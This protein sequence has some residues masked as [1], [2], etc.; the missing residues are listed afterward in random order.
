MFIHFQLFIPFS[1]TVPFSFEMAGSKQLFG[2]QQISNFKQTSARPRSWPCFRTCICT[3]STNPWNTLQKTQIRI[4]NHHSSY[5]QSH[6]CESIMTIPKCKVHQTLGASLCTLGAHLRPLNK[7]AKVC[8]WC[9]MVVT[10]WSWNYSWQFAQIQGTCN[11]S[12]LWLFYTDAFMWIQTNHPQCKP[13]CQEIRKPLCLHCTASYLTSSTFREALEQLTSKRRKGE[14]ENALEGF[15]RNAAVVF[16]KRFSYHKTQV[17][18][19]K[20][21][22]VCNV[23]MSPLSPWA[24]SVRSRTYEAMLESDRISKGKWICSVAVYMSNS[25]G[26]IHFWYFQIV[27]L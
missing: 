20:K 25:V 11:A 17:F 19:S 7:I 18:M 15:R 23:T 4:V 9:N 6:D 27:V 8:I 2:R 16:C 24:R 21:P 3:Q 22:T 12:A 1:F 13:G 5:S 14:L 26:F 10:Y